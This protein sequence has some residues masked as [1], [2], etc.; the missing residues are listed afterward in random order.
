MAAEDSQVIRDPTTTSGG[1]PEVSREEVQAAIAKV[2]ELRALRAALVHGISTNS[3]SP[4]SNFRF[5][6][7]APLAPVL[8]HASLFSTQDYPVFTPSYKGEPLLVCHRPAPR[9][10]ALPG[11]LEENGLSGLENHRETE[12]LSSMKGLASNLTSSE[13]HVCPAEDKKSVTRSM[14]ETSEGAEFDRSSCNQCKPAVIITESGN[15][16][17]NKKNL[18]TVVPVTNSSSSVTVPMSQ[19]KGHGI[20]LSWLFPQLKKKHMKEGSSNRIEPGEVC[21]ISNDPVTTSVEALKNELIEAIRHRD[22]ALME[23]TEMKSSLEELRQKLE[24][25]ETYCKRLKRALRQATQVKGS[26]NPEKAPSRRKP[27]SGNWDSSMP[28]SE[29]EMKERFLQMVSESRLS[30]KKFCKVLINQIKEVD[31]RLTDNINSLLQPYNTT[32][33]SSN[34]KAALYHFEAIINQMLY[35]DFENCTFQKNGPPKIL[36][37]EQDR[38]AQFASFVALRCLS[39]NEVLRKGTKYYSKEFSR[40]CDRKM[41]SIIKSLNWTCPWPE[42]LL[43]AFFVAAKYIWLLHLLAFSF[44]PPLGILRVEENRAFNSHYMENIIADG[45]RSNGLSRV[46]VMVMPG[47]YVQ[48]KVLRCKVLCMC[49]LVA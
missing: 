20:S 18:K 40:F 22:A 19:A 21:Q 8:P 46:K 3:G 17:S 9:N 41:S 2:V 33:N 16:S 32:V 29:E 44:S 34:S 30:V 49:K 4:S 45:Q 25:L 36:D 43:R 15:A 26:L 24:Y 42:Q 23:V 1:N 7:S 48:E 39:W 28:V 38:K 5:P 6:T 14:L 12:S 35:E 27:S 10:R 31:I 37:R 11:N 47:F 13:L